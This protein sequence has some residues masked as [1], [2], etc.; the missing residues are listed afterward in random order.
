MP[1]ISAAH[2]AA[3]I[4]GEGPVGAEIAELTLT[5]GPYGR[6]VFHHKRHSGNQGSQASSAVTGQVGEFRR[7]RGI[8]T[9]RRRLP[10]RSRTADCDD[11][12]SF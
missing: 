3:T 4:A 8:P 10:G 9:S 1:R 11:P 2:M 5:G 6:P 12:A 7:D